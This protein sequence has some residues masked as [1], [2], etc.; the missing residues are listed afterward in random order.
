MKLL[1]KATMLKVISTLRF[2]S[3]PRRIRNWICGRVAPFLLDEQIVP[4]NLVQRKMRG[5][6]V[7]LPC[8]T[9]LFQHR[10]AYWFGELHATGI[11]KYLRRELKPGDTVVDVG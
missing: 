7:T 9:Y 2:F 5:L 10:S 8:N 1:L 3:L 11:D 6:K 4:K